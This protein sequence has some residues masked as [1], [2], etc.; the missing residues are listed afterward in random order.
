MIDAFE[1]GE[2]WL[3]PGWWRDRRLADLAAYARTRGAAIRLVSAGH[4][5]PGLRILG[6]SRESVVNDNSASLVLMLGTR[7][8]N[9]FV[10]GTWTEVRWTVFSPKAVPAKPP[11]SCWPITGAAAE[12]PWNSWTQCDLAAHWS[13]VVGGTA[14][15]TRTTRSSSAWINAEF[16]CGGPITTAPSSFRQGLTA[17]ASQPNVDSTEQAHRE[18]TEAKNEQDQRGHGKQGSSPAQR[19]MLRPQRGMPVTHHN[20]IP[21]HTRYIGGCP[22][23]SA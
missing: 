15:V 8:W 17:G 20:R 2:L 11:R 13:R 16:H 4:R 1:I 18:K 22:C 19:N 23:V 12:H 9:L 5:A 14:S 7:P 21:S 3:G 10:P 6:P